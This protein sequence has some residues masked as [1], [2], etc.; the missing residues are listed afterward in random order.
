MRSLT[1]KAFPL[2]HTRRYIQRQGA[3][4]GY[5]ATILAGAR[6]DFEFDCISDLN[7]ESK[8]GFEEMSAILASPENQTRVN[9]DCA[10]F[11]DAART[12]IV[13][14]GDKNVSTQ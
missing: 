14:L 10:A 1:G 9:E 13:V 2:S 3:D 4:H 8:A 5:S 12:K 11:M 6:S 7:F